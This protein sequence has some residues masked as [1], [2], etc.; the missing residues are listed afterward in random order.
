MFRLIP[1]TSGTLAHCESA[2]ISCLNKHQAAWGQTSEPREA[3]KYLRHKQTVSCNKEK[4]QTEG[5]EQLYLATNKTL[6]WTRF[7]LAHQ[8]CGVFWLMS[9]WTCNI[10]QHEVSLKGESRMKTVQTLKWRFKY[11]AE[12]KTWAAT[13]GEQLWVCPITVNSNFIEQTLCI[14][15]EFNYE[16]V[17]LSNSCAFIQNMEMSLR[18]DSVLQGA[19]SEP[20]DF[21]FFYFNFG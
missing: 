5:H 6:Q 16:N 17:L 9:V 12:N 4:L 2:C 13:H 8:L 19:P 1:N 3:A 14:Q 21:S 11:G 10:A 15:S 18:F 7:K 20:T